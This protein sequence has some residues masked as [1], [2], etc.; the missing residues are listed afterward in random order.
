MEGNNGTSQTRHRS[1]AYP[2]ISLRS[3]VEKVRTL[4]PVMKRNAISVDSALESLNSKSSTG[5]RAIAA[6]M[7]YGFLADEGSGPARKVRFTPTGY[8]LNLLS[9]DDP[10]WIKIIQEAAVK[11]KIYREMAEEW[12]GSLP[13]DSTISKFLTLGKSYN[14]DVIR[15]LIKDFRDTFDFAK[16]DDSDTLSDDESD[17]EDEKYPVAT[18]PKRASAS[19][20]EE[21]NRSTQ[22]HEAGSDGPLRDDFTRASGYIE[23]PLLGDGMKALTIQLPEMRQAL[24]YLPPDY[25]IDDLDSV[26]DHIELWSR[27]LKRPPK[28]NR[29]IDV[30][31]G[32][33]LWKTSAGDYSVIVTG[34]MGERDGRHYVKTDG[35]ETGVPLDEIEYE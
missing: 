3:A 5:L 15:G 29:E 34:Y 31:F 11:P 35:S 17:I 8:R 18:A 33:A 7:M 23:S 1:P 24:L 19:L 12:P 22:R 2:G 14:P 25:T 28:A 26:K 10:E 4:Y 32:K 16:L 9:E 6:L 13:P 27:L 21:V 30:R 20:Y